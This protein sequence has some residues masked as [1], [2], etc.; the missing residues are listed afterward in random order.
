MLNLRAVIL[1]GFWAKLRSGTPGS[2]QFRLEVE[3]LRR[4]AI[5]A[6]LDREIK[7]GKPVGGITVL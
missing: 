2:V 7:R 5:F 4:K 6:A 3:P 1:E